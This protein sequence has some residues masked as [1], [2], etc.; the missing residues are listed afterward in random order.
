LKWLDGSGRVHELNLLTLEAK[1]KTKFYFGPH[2]YTTFFG[3]QLVFCDGFGYAA[4]LLAY[5]TK[6]LIHDF[7]SGIKAMYSADKDNLFIIDKTENSR[8]LLLHTGQKEIITIGNNPERYHAA[9]LI[10][11]E[12]VLITDWGQAHGA[13]ASYLSV[14][15]PREPY[16]KFCTWHDELWSLSKG[17]RLLQ[18]HDARLFKTIK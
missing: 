16:L 14:A 6:T 7:G 13:H 10:K 12:P 3:D 15:T 18:Y 5:K 1:L 17:R 2:P 9:F 8:L 4:K 11:G